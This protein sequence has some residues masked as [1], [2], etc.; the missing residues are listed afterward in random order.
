MSATAGAPP[1]S[2]PATLPGMAGPPGSMSGQQPQKNIYSQ[3]EQMM[4]AVKK[5][6]GALDAMKQKIRDLEE[7]RNKK[8]PEVQ[9]RLDESEAQND[10]LRRKAHE[11]DLQVDQLRVDMQHL[12]NIYN[13]ERRKH[14]ELQQNF[15]Q[16]EQE[17]ENYRRE[18]SGLHREMQK[19]QELKSHNQ[20]LMLQMEKVRTQMA[21]D[22]ET[23]AKMVKAHEQQSLKA[24]KNKAEMTSHI[25][26]V[27]EQV[28]V[29]KKELREADDF[30]ASVVESNMQR[31]EKLC[32]S[33]D[34]AQMM[35]EDYK[36]VIQRR[37]LEAQTQDST[38][39]AHE[40]QLR[41]VKEE[42]VRREAQL[43]SA[44]IKINTIE[45]MRMKEKV[46]SRAKLNDSNET[47]AK[48]RLNIDSFEIE[49]SDLRQQMNLLVTDRNKT[50]VDIDSLKK[51]L[52]NAELSKTS[53]DLEI[54][55]ELQNALNQKDISERKAQ[56]SVMQ[57]DALHAQ[58]RDMQTRHWEDLQKQKE[59]ETNLIEDVERLSK[60]LDDANSRLTVAEADKSKVEDYVKTEVN[61]ASKMVSTLRFEL[62]KRLEELS[63]VRKEKES[64]F[65]DKE[66]LNV[67][68]VEIE[69]RMKSN[70]E[71][72][73]KTIDVDRQK[74]K[75][76]VRVKMNRL[77]T[78]ETEKQE[79]LKESSQLMA[80]IT[81]FKATTDQALADTKAAKLAQEEV[82][83]EL[84]ALKTQHAKLGEDMRVVVGRETNLKEHFVRM[85][86][87]FKEDISRLDE[88]VKQSKKTAAQQVADI[89]GHHKTVSDELEDTRKRN[90]V[91]QEAE[92]RVISELNA[93]K[94][95]MELTVRS[96]EE[97]QQKISKEVV[98]YKREAQELKSKLALANDVKNRMEMEM[99]TLRV[100]FTKVE[101]EGQHYKDVVCKELEHRAGH[102]NEQLKQTQSELEQASSEIRRQK[103]MIVDLEENLD[104]K[105]SALEKLNKECNRIK[106]EETTESK[107][108]KLQLTTNEQKLLECTTMI[109]M[110]Q[111][112]LGDGQVSYHKLQTTSNQTISGLL[113]EL[114]HTEDLLSSERKKFQYENE[115][116]CAKITELH[117]LLDKARDTME[118]STVRT[119]QDR[120]DKELRMQQQEQEIE[121]IRFG[122]AT[123]DER[124]SELEKLR[125]DDRVKLHEMREQVSNHER[126]AADART[127][128]E[129]EQTQRHR[130]EAKITHLEQSLTQALANPRGKKGGQGQGR[131]EEESLGGESLDSVDLNTPA[132]P[133]R[134]IQQSNTYNDYQSQL[135]NQQ[136]RQQNSQ[137]Q[138]Q[139]QQNWTANGLGGQ[140]QMQT[141]S[142]SQS[143][144]GGGDDYY[145]EPEP[146]MQVYSSAPR[147]G[148]TQPPLK[149]Q[150]QYLPSQGH[151]TLAATS[152]FI[153]EKPISAPSGQDMSVSVNSGTGSVSFHGSSGNRS[154]VVDRVTSR[155]ARNLANESQ[156]SGGQ[157][158]GDAADPAD[159]ADAS[160]RD[161]ISRAQ[162]MIERKLAA[163][164]AAQPDYG[165]TPTHQPSEK[166]TY[167]SNRAVSTSSALDAA[168][169]ALASYNSSYGEDDY[170][171]GDA[172]SG[173][174]KVQYG[175][176]DSAR[177][178]K[179]EPAVAQYSRA[180]NEVNEYMESKRYRNQLNQGQGQGHG[181]DSVNSS[182]SSV[183]LTAPKLRPASP[184]G[185]SSAAKP[186]SNSNAAGGGLQY[187]NG[188]AGGIGEKKK[189]KS[190]SHSLSAPSIGLEK[191]PLQLPKINTNGGNDY[192]NEYSANN[193]TNNS[194]S[195]SRH[196]SRGGSGGNRRKK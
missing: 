163:A 57:F 170:G 148:Q 167:V 37:V 162:L 33:L 135:P 141:Q 75:A 123:K 173:A 182:Q 178:E 11:S 101:N 78:L 120:S 32:M 47:I 87:Q 126:L 165:A 4:A 149:T 155:L 10:V 46:E 69:R 151:V 25:L 90:I 50:L 166:T 66:A 73:Q 41:Q 63:A 76:E 115:T 18:I 99:M 27:T 171:S 2:G 125:Q 158:R 186:S 111:K 117:T 179:A 20:Q 8:L 48:L 143:Q 169:A 164:A 192:L 129:L 183:Q 52:T 177:K 22:N 136:N 28:R 116:A 142:Q 53:K 168:N 100:E 45:E 35:N 172:D 61:N 81:E 92:K 9:R 187:Y 67:K 130:L 59:V 71:N 80:Q 193:S 122:M 180:Q 196:G 188:G 175:Y 13:D 121:R 21:E 7:I 124:I 127:N 19:A 96:H 191:E 131:Y 64:L 42:L 150:Q 5:E 185:N 176:G 55:R 79:L 107:K 146:Q 113:E 94:T 49:I 15:I 6:A 62:E 36:V 133:P 145:D 74:L 160:V 44:D 16:Q 86:S 85:E 159:A 139:Q 174:G 128:L 83:G 194:G 82:Q 24:E 153:I 189:S 23:H 95:E 91:L 26:N 17:M 65:A 132:T 98:T 54:Q 104:A 105:S 38:V 106:R 140:P 34:R 70:E 137:F 14:G 110:L 184:P 39:Q 108:L 40:I 156:G 157:G 93:V 88:L 12:N 154:P 43:E 138:N 118:E 60:E 31:N 112:E 190:Q 181:G 58:I 147:G 77:N 97:M 1:V 89:S 103:M 195:N 152:D 109:T 68:L 114:R 144:Y 30:K 56:D 102:T 84:F 161:N 3:L 134:Q 51:Q 29:L 72:F 119:K